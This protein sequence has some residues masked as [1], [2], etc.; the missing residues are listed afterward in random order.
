MWT[1]VTPQIIEDAADKAISEGSVVLRKGAGRLIEEVLKRRGRVV[2]LSVGWSGRFIR[3]CLRTAVGMEAEA[4]GIRANEIEEDG[5]LS[6]YFGAEEDGIWTCGDKVRVLNEFVGVAEEVKMVYVGDS[7]TDLG[8][9]TCV[10]VGICMRGEVEGSEQKEL[11]ETL[12][13]SRIECKWI[14]E[15]KAS[16]KGSDFAKDNACLWWAKDF[17]EIC[18]GLF[19]MG[20]E[21]VD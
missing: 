20:G 5:K 14:L 15:R 2:V 1:G 12:K 9:L 18:E 11:C 10:D 19:C 8:C 4:V 21:L 16:E 3:A 6:R 13:R 7:V 17:H